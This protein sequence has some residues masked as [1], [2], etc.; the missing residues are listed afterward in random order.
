MNSSYL[1][2]INVAEFMYSTKVVMAQTSEL[3]QVLA[4]YGFTFAM[5][6]AQL[7]YFCW[8]STGHISVALLL[9]V[10]ERF[11]WMI[12]PQGPTCGAI[13]YERKTDGGYRDKMVSE[14]HFPFVKDEATI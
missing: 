9:P 8:S 6:Y 2:G 1:A 14:S 12:C 5:L 3:S 11:D 13:S 4:L 7:W 10:A